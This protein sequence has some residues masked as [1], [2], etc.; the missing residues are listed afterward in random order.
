MRSLVLS[1]VAFAGIVSAASITEA[2]T[3]FNLPALSPG[4]SGTFAQFNP[5]LGTLTAISL[6]WSNVDLAEQVTAYAD[7]QN[8]SASGGA[9]LSNSLTLPELPVLND[10]FLFTSGTVSCVDNGNVEVNVPCSVTDPFSTGPATGGMGLSPSPDFSSYIGLSTVPFTLNQNVTF[11]NVDIIGIE[12]SQ[13]D[14]EQ[15]TIQDSGNLFITYAYTPN[16]QTPE[17]G[18]IGFVLAG[19]MVCYRKAFQTRT[20]APARNPR[21]A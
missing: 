2:I 18:S 13:A 7:I 3:S 1:L 17:P 11:T 19:L 15:L 6:S 14:I 16:A 9:A 10:L 8:T 5:A 12:P 20:M 21:S 4:I